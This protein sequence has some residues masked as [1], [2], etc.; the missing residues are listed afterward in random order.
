MKDLLSQAEP[1]ISLSHA[2]KSATEALLASQRSDGHWCFELEADCTIPA[3]YILMLH[4]LGDLD[5]ELEQKL[6]VYLRARQG[7]D[8]GWPLYYGGKADISCTVKVYYALKLVGDT[9]E[10]PHMQRARECVLSLGGAARSN[11]FTRICLA[12]FEQVPWRAVPF[13]PVE[14]MLLPQWFPFHISK[15][16][17]WSRTVMVPLLILCSLKPRA[18]NPRQ[19]KIAELFVTP[20]KEERRYFKTR[21]SLGQLF[22]LLDKMGRQIERFI[23][24][25]IRLKAIAKAETW[26]T[27]RLNGE[28]GLGAIFPA[29]VNAYEAL[30]L[31]GYDIDH[32]FRQQACQAL[33]NLLVI[34]SHSA[35]CQ[36]CFSPV[37]DTALTALTLQAEGS[38]DSLIAAERA[39]NWLKALQIV[40]GPADWKEYNPNLPAGGWAFEYRN[41]YYP[42]LDDTAVVAWAMHAQVSTQYNQA[43]DRAAIWLAGMQSLN[44]GFA[45]FDQN[46]M[47]YYL[48][49]IPFADH[50]ALLDPPTSDVT[51]RCLTFFAILGRP[52]DQSLLENAIQFLLKEQEDNG[53]WFG[54]WGTNYIYGTW[55]ALVAL[56]AV[57]LDP[58]CADAVRRAVDWLQSKQHGDGGWGENNNSYEHAWDDQQPSTSY[59]TAWALL[60]LMAAGEVNSP[61]VQRGIQYLLRTQQADG[62]WHDL[63]FTAPGFP[64]VFYLR[65]HGYCKYFPLWAL[66]EYQRLKQKQEND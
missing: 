20:A 42:D 47:Y 58:A 11:V 38:S 22:L 54:R 12:M 55:S 15:V 56:M 45:S 6:A 28:D 36:P 60:G 25:K 16:S 19:I 7:K 32:P 1:A 10:M 50:G 23:P 30:V 3:E 48:N 21:S 37:W 53:S 34:E 14:I 59:Q 9:P 49:E 39:L 31:L 33:K 24:K 62:F 41:D 4:Y 27:L 2:I 51:A 17:Y 5:I 18:K 13:I 61:T 66:A 44:G 8:G 46:N 26:F 63:W 35:Y 65:Y 52:Q 64:R 40:D 43:V 57:T 29:M